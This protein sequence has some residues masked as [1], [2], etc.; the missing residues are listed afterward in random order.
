M[1]GSF[2]ILALEANKAYELSNKELSDED[3]K[4]ADKVREFEAS[5]SAT[6][7]EIAKTMIV[8][9]SEALSLDKVAKATSIVYESAKLYD[10]VKSKGVNV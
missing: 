10:N 4:N 9:A 3:K 5:K 7:K 1:A 2:T 8:E 6:Q